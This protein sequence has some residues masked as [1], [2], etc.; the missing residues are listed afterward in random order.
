VRLFRLSSTSRNYGTHDAPSP[1]SSFPSAAPF[2][3]LASPPLRELIESLSAPEDS[4]LAGRAP[5]VP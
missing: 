3:P 4:G 5:I 1:T 2:D